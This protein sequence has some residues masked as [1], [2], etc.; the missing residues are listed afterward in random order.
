MSSYDYIGTHGIMPPSP[1]QQPQ[2]F[3]HTLPPVPVDGTPVPGQYP[4]Q[5]FTGAP[6]QGPPQWP[7]GGPPPWLSALVAQHGALGRAEQL[8]LT[9]NGLPPGLVGNTHASFLRP[10][11]TGF[12]GQGH[13]GGLTA[14]P[15][16]PPM[17]PVGLG[18]V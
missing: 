13:Y 3:P 2:V 1:Y 17:P 14:N 9:Q 10:G 5:A 18:G 12:P 7:H 8:G 4:T 6:F 15:V 11:G 16:H